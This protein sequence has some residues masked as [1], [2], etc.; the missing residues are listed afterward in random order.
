MTSSMTSP[1]CSPDLAGLGRLLRRKG[2]GSVF[3]GL[4]GVFRGTLV[5]IFTC[6]FPNNIMDRAGDQTSVYD[7]R[8]HIP[9]IT[10]WLLKNTSPVVVFCGVFSILCSPGE[11]VR[12]AG[13]IKEAWY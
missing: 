13:A 9:G 1:E 7:I 4:G 10:F 5:L 2:P 8:Q 12:V 11:K 3:E 6:T